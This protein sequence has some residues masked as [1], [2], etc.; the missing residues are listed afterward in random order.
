MFAINLIN[1]LSIIFYL[2]GLFRV[3]PL[4][5]EKGNYK[6]SNP[7]YKKL[8]FLIL[9]GL[10]IDACLLTKNKSSKK[11]SSNN[12]SY[13]NK[14]S[15]NKSS[16]NKSS[17]NKSSNNKSSN[18][19]SSNNKSSNNDSSNKNES[20]YHNKMKNF[21]LLNKKLF[22]SISGIPTSTSNR[23]E[24][25]VTGKP[26]NFLDILSTFYHSKVK[27]DNFVRVAQ[28]KNLENKRKENFNE[29]KSDSKKDDNA[30]KNSYYEEKKNF[31][32]E[33]KNFIFLGDSV[34]TDKFKIKNY[35]TIESYEN[36]HDFKEE[37]KI[38]DKLLNSI[39]NYDT[40]LSHLLFLDHYG[41]MYTIYHEKITEVLK[42]YDELILNIYN[43]MDDDTLFV[44]TSD[45]GVNE[46]GN[47]GNVS[48]HEL[49]SMCAIITKKGKKSKEK[50]CGNFR[51]K[52]LFKEIRDDYLR[53]SCCLET[54]WIEIDHEKNK[55]NNQQKNEVEELNVIHQNDIMPTICNLMGW[56]IPFYNCGNYIHEIVNDGY[57]ELA[58][59]KFK[60]M[61][62]INP[63]RVL[64]II[65]SI[66]RGMDD[67][68]IKNNSKKI[69]LKN[70]YKKYNLTNHKNNKLRDA[71][72]LKTNYILTESL[73]QDLSGCNHT[74]LLIGSI[75]IIISLFLQ[76]RIISRNTIISILTSIFA[77]IMTSHSV[78]SY[79]HEDLFWIALFLSQNFNFKNIIIG[80]I[81]FNTGKFPV[82]EFDRK[83]F[84]RK[85]YYILVFL[86]FVLKSI[87]KLK[88]ILNQIWLP[89]NITNQSSI[90]DE[91]CNKFDNESNNKDDKE[92]IGNDDKEFI[93]NYDK[94]YKHLNQVN[95]FKSIV[96]EMSDFL[97]F[98][99]NNNIKL[100][101]NV[102][103]SIFFKNVGDEF[104]LAFMVLNNDI[105]PFLFD[106]STILCF[107]MLIENINTFRASNI[108]SK[109]ITTQLNK[110]KNNFRSLLNREIANFALMNLYIFLIGMNYSFS[111]LNIH[112]MFNISKRLTILFKIYFLYKLFIE[113]RIHLLN[114]GKIHVFVS[115]LQMFIVFIVSF[116]IRDDM[117]F[118]FFFG[119]RAVF[120][121]FL[122]VLDN[123]VSILNFL[124]VY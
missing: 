113:K 61:S 65:K 14:S 11:K 123:F 97:V 79:I 22:L 58:L 25:I 60:L 50:T 107:D 93:K 10:R 4:I 72:L 62:K 116:V 33:D 90:F 32:N 117:I 45:H 73:Y 47:H 2:K 82:H 66:K 85:S 21:Y 75:L 5:T 119:A 114:Y 46:D 69:N 80:I 48:V 15:N 41:H 100:I 109:Q 74:Y 34:W 112:L 104:A 103:V 78:Y 12:N 13:N 6:P 76:R 110:C 101:I 23:I 54:D 55:V 99:F 39:N 124:G 96:K 121:M 98:M 120:L 59:Q 118:Y 42:A 56:E 49:S 77:S 20:E 44:I 102:I 91:S 94:E 35:K 105:S 87:K 63:G 24:S 86:V 115:T 52:K 30:S 31:K 38:I 3:T 29:V 83:L 26:S 57:E 70:N 95:T 106:V 1:I 19:K 43:K 84:I 88:I 40:I 71:L 51:F 64:K 92:S 16:N 18:K 8:I 27:I 81:L 28:S 17:N 53:P 122:F 111:S 7:K 108:E 89:E 36:T 37:Q 67:F 9:D 68:L